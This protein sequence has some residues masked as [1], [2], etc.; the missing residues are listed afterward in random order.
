[1]L[2]GKMTAVSYENCMK[3]KYICEQSLEFCVK[4][5]GIYSY[6]YA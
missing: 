1:M 6:Q 2:F 5:G 3:H 4:I